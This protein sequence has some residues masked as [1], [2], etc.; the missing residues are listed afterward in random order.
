[1]VISISAMNVQKF[2]YKTFSQRLRLILF[3]SRE[4]LA[5]LT[6]EFKQESR[7]LST[8]FV[9]VADMTATS[10]KK[11]ELNRMGKDKEEP[12]TEKMA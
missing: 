6:A 7:V 5:R 10:R 9:A 12:L 8:V 11:I 4:Y 1:M 2:F 3:S